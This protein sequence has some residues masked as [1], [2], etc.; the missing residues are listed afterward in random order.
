MMLLP[1]VKAGG[2]YSSL[3]V[4]PPVANTA[5]A[6]EAPAPPVL[7]AVEE[8]GNR[9]YDSL[10]LSKFGLTR[11][12]LIYAYQGRE[13]LKKKGVLENFD[14]LTVCDFTL[15]SS[16]KRM[17]IIDV[18]EFKLLMHTYVAHGKN[19]GLSYARKFSNSPSSHKSSLGFYVTKNIYSG[20]HGMSLRLTGMDKGFND[21][22]EARAVVVHGAPYIGEQRAEAAYMGRSLGC[23]AVPKKVAP[24]VINTIKNGSL[25]FIYHPTKTYLTGSKILNG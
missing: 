20:K 24:K 6:T 15:P 3:S 19:S 21:K 5:P 17:F 23:P 22:A 7:N 14:I 8:A 12:A 25:F 10:K 2:R 13:R 4:K 9:L 11:A 16:R 18:K 1:V